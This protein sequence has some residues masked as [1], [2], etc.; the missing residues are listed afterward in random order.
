MSVGILTQRFRIR[1]HVE[2]D[3]PTNSL[4][5]HL[6]CHHETDD[7]VSNP[8]PCSQ[9]TLSS[10]RYSTGGFQRGRELDLSHPN[11]Y[12]VGNDHSLHK[13]RLT[14]CRSTG[15]GDKGTYERKEKSKNVSNIRFVFKWYIRNPLNAYTINLVQGNPYS[16][17]GYS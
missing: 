17:K 7:P 11:N 15:P 4:V 6:L 2:R 10:Q 13:Q 16:I 1:I 12:T 14:S 3:T 9:A 8:Q 5:L